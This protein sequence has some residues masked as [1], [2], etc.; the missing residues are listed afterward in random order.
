[1]TYRT[2]WQPKETTS[3]TNPAESTPKQKESATASTHTFTSAKGA[4]IEL[5]NWSK[6]GMI[7]T[8][9]VLT[10]RVPGNWSFEGT[11]PI[12]IIYEGDIGLPGTTAKLESD[13]MTSELVPFTATLQFDERTRES[14]D[15]MI[16]LRKANPSGNPE[17]DDSLAL[18]VRFS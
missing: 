4:K 15:V 13:W 12:D 5:D 7:T 11:F 6:D 17:N 10:G 2:W 1:M 18:K 14:N 8:P 3:A 16:M 9:F